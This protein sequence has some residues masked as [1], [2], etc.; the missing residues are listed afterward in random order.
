[1][2]DTPAPTEP[3]QLISVVEAAK[4]LGIARRTLEREV[5]RKRFPP[6][7]KIGSKS[8]Y[9]VADLE[10]YLAG[11]RTQRDSTHHPT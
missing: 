9:F 10:R 8:L 1:M 4:R 6:P 7:V 3:S 5:C 11:L 2:S